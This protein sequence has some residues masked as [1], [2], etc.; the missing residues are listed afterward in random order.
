MF[1]YRSPFLFLTWKA[2]SQ[3]L[4]LFLCLAG[5]GY[6]FLGALNLGMH[7]EIPI[8]AMD[9]IPS[10]ISKLIHENSPQYISRKT[11][12]TIDE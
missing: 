3:L 12:S 11:Y 8:W 10:L 2:L 1:N 9:L 5:F 7:K 4:L 6:S